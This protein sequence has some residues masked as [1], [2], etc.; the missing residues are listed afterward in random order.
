MFPLFFGRSFQYLI[1]GVFFVSVEGE[2]LRD[3]QNIHILTT[4]C[5]IIL[6]HKSYT[7]IITKQC[8]P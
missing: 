7:L 1:F 6:Y 4:C 2:P 3:L 5:L 8:M